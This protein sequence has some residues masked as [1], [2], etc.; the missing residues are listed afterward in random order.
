MSEINQNHPLILKT[1][2]G[3]P[4]YSA[5][6]SLPQASEI[7]KPK[8]VKL[9]T[10]R[11]GFLIEEGTGEVIGSGGAMQYSWE[12]VDN[13]RF[14]KLFLAGLKQASGLTK[15]GIT[16]FEHVYNKVREN[17][18]SD[19]ILL[20]SDD[21]DTAHIQKQTY[22][23]GLR[24]LLDKQF[25]FKSPY[26]GMFFINI[27]YMFNGDRLAFVKGYYRKGSRPP[28]IVSNDKQLELFVEPSE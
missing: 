8:K 26:G 27:R 10:D 24:E 7:S 16:V 25:L 2:R 14:V 9:G 18:N 3:V 23:R 19:T 5:N 28:K 6:P 21:P 4:V 20:S 15:A 1:E 13:E 22:Q 12:E 11:K 17:P